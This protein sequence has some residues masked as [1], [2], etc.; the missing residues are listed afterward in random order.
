MS[1]WMNEIRKHFG[2]SEIVVWKLAA[3]CSR[4]LLCECGT[5]ITH[6]L[7]CL[8]VVSLVFGLFVFVGMFVCLFVVVFFNKDQM[9]SNLWT[10]VNS[11]MLTLDLGYQKLSHSAVTEHWLYMCCMWSSENQSEVGSIDC[12]I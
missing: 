11:L 2:M 4:R 1:L 6:E 7:F 9:K 12:E 5:V 3:F 10:K 8:F